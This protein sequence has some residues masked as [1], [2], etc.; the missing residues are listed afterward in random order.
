MDPSCWP[1]LAGERATYDLHENQ[2]HD[3]GYRRFLGRLLGPL[4]PRLDA[5]MHGLDYGCGPGPA[6]A[7]MLR[8]E[9]MPM[10]LYDPIYEPDTDCLERRYDFITCT[11]VAEH[12]HQPAQT[13]ALLRDLLVP[14]GWLAVMTCFQTEDARFEH[15]HYRRDPTHVVFYREETFDWLARN[16][17]WQ[18]VIPAKD[19]ALLRRPPDAAAC[20]S[21]TS[22]L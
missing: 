3:P 16:H 6:L 21:Q 19:I 10:S 5:G 14:G 17:D 18:L 15:W 2:T 7:A 9:G 1:T 4:L 20:G 11:E 13:F 12:L 22:A 8:D